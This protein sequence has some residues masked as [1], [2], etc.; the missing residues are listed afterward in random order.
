MGP[1]I[2]GRPGAPSRGDRYRV[3][4]AQR[5]IEARGSLDRERLV[6]IATEREAR[7]VP[8]GTSL[9]VQLGNFRGERRRLAFVIDEYGDV[10]GLVA[11]E[12]ILEEIVGEFTT[13]PALLHRAIHA[14]KGGSFVVAGSTPLRTVNRRLGW[15]LPTDGPRT[16][17]GAIVEYLEAIPQPG[18]AL[19]LHG[20][21]VEVL[22][23]AENTV[24]TARMWPAA[25]PSPGPTDTRET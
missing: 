3:A 24:R 9:Q 1:S 21:A 23:T 10:L 11:L 25:E 16:L 22:Q 14:E 19:Q 7:F 4:M 2:A 13:Q 12:D 8:A 15:S 6:A 5:V 20:H 17:S 18:T